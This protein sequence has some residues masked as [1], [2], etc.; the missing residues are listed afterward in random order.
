MFSETP[1]RAKAALLFGAEAP[2][3]PQGR[4]RHPGRTYKK[5][6]THEKGRTKLRGLKPHLGGGTLIH[7]D[8]QMPLYIS[9]ELLSRAESRAEKPE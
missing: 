7:E 9:G 3:L 4:G 8:G 5:G 6:R 1:T 2:A